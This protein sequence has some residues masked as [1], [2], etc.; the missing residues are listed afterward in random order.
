MSRVSADRR[1]RNVAQISQWYP[2]ADKIHLVWDSWPIHAHRKVLESLRKQ[3]RLEVLWLP[4]YAR[5][6]NHLEKGGRRVRQ[7]LAPAHPWSDDFLE[8]RHPVRNA[9]ARLASGSEEFKRYV[10]RSM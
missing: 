4:A 1:A 9:F 8:S 10:G 2:P 7:R 6:L 5:W 3:S